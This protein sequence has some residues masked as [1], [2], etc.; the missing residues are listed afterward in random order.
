MTRQ[1][2]PWCP[3][4]DPPRLSLTGPRCICTPGPNRQLSRMATATNCPFT[5]QTIRENSK[6]FPLRSFVHVSIISAHPTFSQPCGLLAITYSVLQAHHAFLPCHLP[7]I[8]SLIKHPTLLI[9]GP[10]LIPQTHPKSPPTS[11]LHPLI[12]AYHLLLKTPKQFLR[13]LPY[14]SNPQ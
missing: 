3:S 12:S 10:S 6:D 2:G 8:S 7:G 14:G 13:Y 11:H 4:G 5:M 9:T 1:A